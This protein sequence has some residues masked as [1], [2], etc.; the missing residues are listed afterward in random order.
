MKAAVFHGQHDLRV[1]E[2][3]VPD[4]RPDD[5]LI[6]VAY[7]GICGSDIHT[8]EGM[9]MNIH[10]RA[11]GPRVIGHEV[12]GVV[13]AV[14]SSVTICQP[15]DRVT[16]IPWVTCGVC[17]YCR[18][19]LVNHCSDKR[20]LGGAFAD[21]VSSP[22]GTV[23]RVPEGIS[24]KR[25]A[26]AEPLSCCVW[27]M[28]LAQ[29]Q[30]GSSVLVVGAG[31]MGL[32]LL[33]LAR[34]GGAAQAI[35]SEPNPVRRALAE[36]LGATVTVNPREVDL[37]QAVYDV[38]DGLGADVAFEAVGQPATVAD[39]IR[40]VRT[41]GTVVIVGVADPAATLPISPFEI[42]QR[43]LTIRGCFTRRLSFDRAMRWLPTLDLDPII[44]HVFP[45][46]G[47]T[48]AMECARHGQGGKV[49][50]A[51]NGESLE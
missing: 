24:L 14:G 40:S 36:Q 17:T 48:E 7:C 42:Y 27:A 41:A 23:F 31:T 12:S 26:L 34:A 10:R 37:R 25:A 49:L 33:A 46:S 3:P 28:D 20:L 22:Q 39:A 38:T 18:R 43:E 5:V 21:Y 45:L 51:P 32:L 44:T 9:Q 13:E 11:A 19:G 30:S 29:V 2:R 4:V 47:M 8:F 50:V 16:C 35:V 6:R 1:E 15:G